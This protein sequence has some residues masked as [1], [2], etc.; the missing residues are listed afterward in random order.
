VKTGFVF[1]SPRK[2]FP[3]VALIVTLY[4]APNGMCVEAVSAELINP[5]SPIRKPHNNFWLTCQGLGEFHGSFTC[6][7]RP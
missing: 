6:Y 4:L 2:I 7:M 1:L 3:K 5:L